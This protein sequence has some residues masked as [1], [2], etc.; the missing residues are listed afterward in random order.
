MS[1]RILEEGT[2]II[3]EHVRS[4]FPVTFGL[5]SKFPPTALLH[6]DSDI[7]VG[8][9]QSF[10][11]FEKLRSNEV[12]VF[13]EQVAGE[14]HGFDIR[15]PDDIDI[16]N[17]KAEDPPFDESLRRTIAYLEECVARSVRDNGGVW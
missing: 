12:R 6:G 10:E 7:L 17:P 16:D 4:I 11:V 15:F 8:F 1:K 3:P 9:N 14:G 2:D 5:S 13:L